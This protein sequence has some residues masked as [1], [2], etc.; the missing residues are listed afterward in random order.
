MNCYSVN[1]GMA[2]QN[3]F[4]SAKMIAVL[5]VISGG[6]YKL[7]HGNVQHLQ[8]AFSKPAPP[9]GAIAGNSLKIVFL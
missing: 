4:T 1:L 5:I 9:I 3:I 7:Y 6:A 8:S 2:V